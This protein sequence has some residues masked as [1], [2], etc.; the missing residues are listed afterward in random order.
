[1]LLCSTFISYLDIA[2]K[3][4]VVSLYALPFSKSYGHNIL[5]FPLYYF[6][7]ISEEVYCI[8][9]TRS[10]YRVRIS[11]FRLWRAWKHKKV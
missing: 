4:L 10:E 1:L 7:L 9:R 8:T 6:N 5:I 2:L 3:L 11:W